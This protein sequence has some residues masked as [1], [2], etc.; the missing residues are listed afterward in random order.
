MA[1]HSVRQGRSAQGKL[2]SLE[3]GWD[4]E[5]IVSFLKNIPPMVRGSGDEDTLQIDGD[6][7]HVRQQYQRCEDPAPAPEQ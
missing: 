1:A 6:V 7:G 4:T 3:L 5:S 2:C